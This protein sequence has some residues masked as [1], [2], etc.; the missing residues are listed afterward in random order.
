MATTRKLTATKDAGSASRKRR[1]GTAGS[2]DK[3]TGE[4][5][6]KEG[7][8]RPADRSKGRRGAKAGKAAL[9]EANVPP[10][11]TRSARRNKGEEL[12]ALLKRPMGATLPE[13]IDASGWQAHS[14]RGF[15]SGTVKKRMGLPIESVPD[16][17]GVRRYRIKA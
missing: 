4:R 2:T 16:A 12:I 1:T 3:I 10:A 7:R 13:L 11:G 8:P 9:P 6:V 17:Q 14:V 15:L 5:G